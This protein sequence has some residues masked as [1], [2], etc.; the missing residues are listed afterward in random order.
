[1]S[2]LKSH[3]RCFFC[4][5]RGCKYENWKRWIHKKDNHNA[6][7]GV[8]SNW[9]TD[10]IVACARFKQRDVVD[11]DIVG[12]FLKYDIG[13]IINLQERN[14][15]PYCGD[16]NLKSGFSYDPETFMAQGVH[17][18]HMGWPDLGVPT[19]DKMVDIVQ[20]MSFVLSSRTRIAVHCHAG[21]G[22]TGLTIA[23]Y[24]V[25]EYNIDPI[26][27]I[28]DV[29]AH[30]SRAVQNKKQEEFVVQFYQKL[31]ELRLTFALNSSRF[32]LEDY[33]RRQRR[34]LHG[35]DVIRYRFTPKITQMLLDRILELSSRSGLDATAKDFCNYHL[36]AQELNR[37]Q[38]VKDGINN[39]TMRSFADV[40]QVHILAK[41]LVCWF[42]HLKE[43]LIPRDKVEILQ[44]KSDSEDL[45]VINEL[46]EYRRRTLLQI[47]TFTKKFESV[48]AGLYDR[49]LVRIA[50]CVFG[51]G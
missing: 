35:G 21:L 25:F 26:Q 1:M 42:A 4:G 41:L 33:L 3:P 47:V 28:L 34:Y 46:Q 20:I 19:F 11:H 5:G 50:N 14:E 15:H 36:S 51:N 2:E 24:L 10:R 16:G 31:N 40:D 17:F 13:A 38:I 45:Q 44:S 9:V 29:R 27:A 43:P 18:Y 32:L 6:I 39:G 48:E 7:D 23:C 30:R 22:R 37:L 49:M 12:Q 8:Y